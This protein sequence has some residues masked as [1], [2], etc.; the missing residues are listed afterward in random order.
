MSSTKF[1]RFPWAASGDKIDIPDTVPPSGAVSYPQG[2]GPDYERNPATDPL[3]KRVPRDETNQLYYDLTSNLRAWQIGA[4]PEWVTAAQNGG[5]AVTYP[6]GS[7]VRHDQSGAFVNYMALIETDGEPGVSADWT[8]TP[9]DVTN[10][11][12]LNRTYPEV[13]TID[14]EMTVT[15]I[16]GNIVL[17]ETSETWV[18]RGHRRFSVGDFLLADRTLAHTANKTYHLRWHAPGTGT[19]TPE[20]TYPNGRFELADMTALTED[21]AQYDSTYDRVLIAR[22]VTNGANVATVT[23]IPNAH[24]IHGT[25]LVYKSTI[26]QSLDWTELL[27]A[28]LAVVLPRTPRDLT[29]SIRMLAATT[30]KPD[31]AAMVNA[32][33]FLQMHGVRPKTGTT[34]YGG[35]VEYVFQDSQYSEGSIEVEWR[36]F[37]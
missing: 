15:S 5:T 29:V 1:F 32:T 30:G 10:T 16:G 37:A 27:G 9:F 19:A 26:S 33:G 35:A 6:A 13:E 36:Y 31:G 20:A 23:Q 2:F 25:A 3:A 12:R 17:S 11:L 22:V 7:L 18:W 14:N 8:T 21:D 4:L 34:R 28:D 24:E